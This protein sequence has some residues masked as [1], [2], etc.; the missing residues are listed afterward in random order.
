MELESCPVFEPRFNIAPGQEVPVVGQERDGRRMLR[1]LKWGLV[2]F[3]ARDPKTG[4]RTILARRETVA[5][6]P[7]FREAFR[8]RRCLLVADGFYEWKRLAGTKAKAPYYVR[9][10]AGGVFGFAGLWERWKDPAGERLMTCALITK[11][12]EGPLVTLHDRMPVVVRRDDYAAWLDPG[13]R[14]ADILGE[15]LQGVGGEAFE[16]YEVSRT[17]NQVENEGPGLIEPVT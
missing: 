14:E 9:L 10:R 4:Y 8:Y 5:R 1:F 11:P 12:A 3:W 13:L 6:R 16:C 17:V 2:P 15:I 7:A